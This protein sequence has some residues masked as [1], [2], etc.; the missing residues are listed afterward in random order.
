VPREPVKTS[1]RQLAEVALSSSVLNTATWFDFAS[2]A[3]G[4][5]ALIDCLDVVREKVRKVRSGDLSDPEA[6][7][8]AQAIALDAI[9]NTL[10]R[11]A[12]ANI[13]E[14]PS[15]TDMYLRLA[16]KAQGQCRAT[17]ETLV[18]T[19]NPQPTSFVKQANV[20]IGGP[21]QVVNNPEGAFV[22]TPAAATDR[23]RA[24][25][26]DGDANK[27]LGATNGARLDGAPEGAAGK[28]DSRLETV[29]V[30]HRSPN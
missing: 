7:L 29:G 24:D 19:K 18:E 26:L 5:I 16:L 17:L 27:L 9:F 28:V 10:A 21:Q 14:Y 15:V 25:K 20:A 3:M 11:R 30:V 12:A 1:E 22:P 6:M 13:G 23:A 2:P 8:T 4:Q